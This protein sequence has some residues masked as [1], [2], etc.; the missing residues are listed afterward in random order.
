MSHINIT[1]LSYVAHGSMLITVCVCVC[2]CM[3]VRTQLRYD[4][5]H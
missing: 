5:L 4:V 3:C 1:E 2:V